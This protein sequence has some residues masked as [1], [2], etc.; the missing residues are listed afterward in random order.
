MAMLIIQMVIL[1]FVSKMLT[2][3]YILNFHPKIQKDPFVL[4]QLTMFLGEIPWNSEISPCFPPRRR[5]D[6]PCGDSRGAHAAICGAAMGISWGFSF[7]HPLSNHFF[8]TNMINIRLLRVISFSN[9]LNI[10]LLR[11]ISFS[12]MINIRLL[13]VISFSNMINIRLLRVI[14]F[15]N[16]LH[17]LNIMGISGFTIF[18]RFLSFGILWVNHGGFPFGLGRDFSTLEWNFGIRHWL[19]VWNM[20]GTMYVYI[21]IIYVYHYITHIIPG[22][23]F[24][25]WILF[26]ISYMGC[27]PSNIDELHHFSRWAHCTTNQMNF[28]AFFLAM[29]FWWPH[30]DI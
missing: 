4:V 1:S 29:N 20:N 23:W 21:Y 6:T 12:N 2:S 18:P 17:L 14:S 3:T 10:R 22:W 13:R 26:S 19:V 8:S 9:M 5:H 11:V 24:Q 25:T 16:S 27:H 15:S 28:R 30:W 7:G